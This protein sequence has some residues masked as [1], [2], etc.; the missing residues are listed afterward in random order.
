V[1]HVLVGDD[2]AL[3]VLDPAAGSRNACSSSS[4]ALPEFG[5]ASTS[6]SGSSSIR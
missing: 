3:E 5:P 1:V 2:D 4:S 6:V